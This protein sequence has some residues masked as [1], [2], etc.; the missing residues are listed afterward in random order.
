VLKSLPTF[1]TRSGTV[2]LKV[3]TSGTTVAIDG[4]LLSR[5]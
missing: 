3:V 4:L 5:S 1:S 2:T